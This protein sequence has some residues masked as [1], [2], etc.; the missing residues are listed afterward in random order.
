MRFV[1]GRM[2]FAGQL[3]RSAGAGRHPRMLG[4]FLV[5]PAIRLTALRFGP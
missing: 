3:Q 5:L 2:D 1:R 4:D